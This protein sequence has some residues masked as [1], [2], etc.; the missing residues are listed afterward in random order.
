MSIINYKNY[1]ILKNHFLIFYYKNYK[2]VLQNYYK[3]LY[4]ST[5]TSN[6]SK[7]KKLQTGTFKLLISSNTPIIKTS[8]ST[9]T[10]MQ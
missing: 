6:K 8:I 1:K 7:L 10:G 4:V 2:L 3:N 5:Y 9:G